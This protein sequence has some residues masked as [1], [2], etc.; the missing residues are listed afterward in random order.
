MCKVFLRRGKHPKVVNLKSRQLYQQKLTISF[1]SA[2]YRWCWHHRN[3]QCPMTE[4]AM[5]T[6]CT[7]FYLWSFHV[8]L[9]FRDGRHLGEEAAGQLQDADLPGADRQG[10]DLH[11]AQRCLIVIKL[12][13]MFVVRFGASL[14]RPNL[15]VEFRLTWCGNLLMEAPSLGQIY[16]PS[17]DSS[18]QASSIYADYIWSQMLRCKL[19]NLSKSFFGKNYRA[20]TARKAYGVLYL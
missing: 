5:M 18:G 14:W 15:T 3:L 13:E 9:A 2:Q 16:G 17:V 11:Q 7:E 10:E 8:R 1:A 6:L 12:G 4:F 20:L 19:I